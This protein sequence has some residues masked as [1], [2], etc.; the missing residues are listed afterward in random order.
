M[1]T[2]VVLLCCRGGGGVNVL[3]LQEERAPLPQIILTKKENDD[4][5]SSLQ[6]QSLLSLIKAA[7]TSE[8]NTVETCAYL[9]KVL[10]D[11][12]HYQRQTAEDNQLV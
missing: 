5:I 11:V 6:V 3:R 12:Y 8:P 4:A 10:Q 7:P 2:K 1:K 9:I